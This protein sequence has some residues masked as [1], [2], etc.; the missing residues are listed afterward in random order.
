MNE[1]ERQDSGRVR[2]LRLNRPPS[3][4]LG[5]ALLDALLAELDAAA[6]DA[7]V[8]VVVLGSSS[9]KYFS[10]GLDIDEMLGL[11][12]SE[13][14]KLFERM[15]TTHR[16]LAGLGKPTVAAIEGYALLG[17]F[18]L[19]LG[20]DW[21][22]ISEK[23]GKVALSEV[24]IGLSPTAPL[25][26]LVSALSGRPGLIKDLVLRGSTLRAEEAYEAGLVDRL[27]PA[28]SFWDEV[29]RE[30]ERLAKLPPGAYAAIQKSLR[31]A[32]L[33]ER[34]WTE[35]MLEFRALFGTEEAREGLSAMRDKR[36][37]R[38]Q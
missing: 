8:R 13:Q 31:S 32:L 2:V 11:P 35:G 26:R 7:R 21:R 22:L 34:L 15:V 4:G 38:W 33:E 19:A 28:E 24:R 17:G 12:G 6:A 25:L 14:P 27:L 5:S 1:I 18:I 36:K 23:T 30:G 20:C 10:S 9:P 3:N 16:R 29:L 37:P